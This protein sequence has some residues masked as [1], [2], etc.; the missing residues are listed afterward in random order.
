VILL[1][2]CQLTAMLLVDLGDEVAGAGLDFTNKC[3]K[4]FLETIGD[5]IRNQLLHASLLHICLRLSV[6]RSQVFDDGPDPGRVPAPQVIPNLVWVNGALGSPQGMICRGDGFVGV[7]GVSH[8][9]FLCC[10]ELVKGTLCRPSEPETNQPTFFQAT[11]PLSEF[12]A[13]KP[14]L[15]GCSQQSILLLSKAGLGHLRRLAEWAGSRPS[16]QSEPRSGRRT[17]RRLLHLLDRRWACEAPRQEGRELSFVAIFSNGC[18][19]RPVTLKA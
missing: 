5:A 14:R 12:G 1:L 11:E 10:S 17:C 7:F 15:C 16:P 19:L 2:K 3:R 4:S 18:C 13:L 9:G 8:V 6:V